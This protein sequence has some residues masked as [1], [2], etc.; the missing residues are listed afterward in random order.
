MAATSSPRAAEPSSPR[1]LT[2]SPRPRNTDSSTSGSTRWAATAATRRWTEFAPRSTAAPTLGRRV[3]PRFPAERTWPFVAAWER[4]PILGQA[5]PVPSPVT[6]VEPYLRVRGVRLV[7]V[8]V[9]DERR[10]GLAVV[11]RDVDDLAVP[12]AD[13]TGTATLTATVG[14]AA[15]GFEGAAFAGA[16]F[17]GALRPPPSA[18]SC[19]RRSLTPAVASDTCLR[20]FASTSSAFWSR[21]SRRARSLA[22]PLSSADPVD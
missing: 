12:V 10:V 6:L 11:R 15:A 8:D 14:F 22:L 20:R 17:A 3:V 19:A 5:G 1:W 7:A 9:P 13:R 2:A 18:V 21:F 4:P 16:A